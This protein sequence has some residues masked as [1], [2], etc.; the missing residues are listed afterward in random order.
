MVRARGLCP[1]LTLKALRTY[2]L[3][4]NQGLLGAQMPT[5]LPLWSARGSKRVADRRESFDR[6]R[7]DRF[8]LLIGLI[9]VSMAL[10]CKQRVV[11]A[12]LDNHVREIEAVF[13]CLAQFQL[14][15]RLTLRLLEIFISLNALSDYAH[16]WVYFRIKSLDKVCYVFVALPALDPLEQ[17]HV[18]NNSGGAPRNTRGAMDVDIQALVVQHIV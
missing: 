15:S 7:K 13:D 6:G 1:K 18:R 2:C 12:L 16:V 10:H 9:V 17:A 14:H 5:M 3:V 11:L 4:R 8:G